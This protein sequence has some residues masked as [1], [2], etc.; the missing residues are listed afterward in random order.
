MVWIFAD[1]VLFISSIFVSSHMPILL[2]M[3]K[4]IMLKFSHF[5]WKTQLVYSL[6]MYSYAKQLLF[7][8]PIS[9]SIK[10]SISRRIV[11]SLGRESKV[12]VYLQDLSASIYSLSQYG[13]RVLVLNS[14][15]L[16]ASQRWYKH[17]TFILHFFVAPS[18]PRRSNAEF[19]W[20]SWTYCWKPLLRKLR[21]T[22]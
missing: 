7:T 11:Q 6:I 10:Q 15:H 14:S 16:H 3:K 21:Q 5:S 8:G 20:V 19:P 17:N 1:M 9:T 18:R 13:F 4:W 12:N 2:R 22:L